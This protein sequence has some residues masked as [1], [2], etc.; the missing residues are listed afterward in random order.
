MRIR[1]IL[2]LLVQ[3]ALVAA[4]VVA[5]A[6][7]RLPLGIPG[8]WEWLRTP[9]PTTLIGPML[10]GMAVV[11]YAVI[12]AAGLRS[13]ADARR[14]AGL[15]REGCWL[16]TLVIAAIAIQAIIPTG[17]PG[18]F[19]LEK[20]G[21][22]NFTPSSSGYFRVAREQAARDPWAFLANYPTWIQGQDTLHIGT[23]PPGLIVAQ[24]LLMRAMER[25][26]GVAGAIERMMPV[27]A[28]TGLRLFE[29][30]T[31]YPIPQSD[32]AALYLTSLITL[33]AC[34]GTVAPLYVLARATAGP[35]V[36]WAAAAFWPVA[37]APVLFQ[38]I[39]DAAYPFLSSSALALAA[40]AARDDA[41][42]R[43][44]AWFLAFA[45]GAVLAFGCTFTLAFLP[46]GLIVGI[47]ILSAPGVPARRKV[48][49]VAVVGVAFLSL[50]ALGWA[51]TSASPI[52]IW[53][54]NLRKHAAFYDEYPRSYLPWLLVNP[55]ELSVALGLPAAAWCACGLLGVRRTPRAASITFGVLVL[56]DLIGRNMG[57]VAR[58]WML[59]LPPLLLAAGAGMERL[60]AGPAAM[61]VTAALLGFQT[62]A[63]QSM[64]QVVLPVEIGARSKEH[65]SHPHAQLGVDE[66]ELAAADEA[67]IGRQLD[68]L[69]AVA[70]ELDHVPRL[71]VREPAEREIDAA[72]LD[73]EG[74]GH[75]QRI[76]V[77]IRRG[78]AG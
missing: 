42:G 7:R 53:R 21:Y 10:A 29:D 4:L 17:A 76:D 3:A 5:V 46:V 13:L 35:R 64:I 60:G 25:S 56:L 45:S 47:L 12:V 39:A 15:V 58:L 43:R 73:G 77:G 66:D 20:W 48:G 54:W 63:I 78:A 49:L 16:A 40:W 67:A 6:G 1:A 19:G 2:I 14:P 38:P 9:A 8:E 28:T 52:T 65:V 33:L 61:A 70:A 51:V 26:P 24:C 30:A 72:Q 41:A 36:A 62:L 68:G 71:E 55:V 69:A 18:G 75:V 37:T 32:R 22:A 57:E 74:D 31:S 59:F 27:A 50:T 11:G 34:A 23:H 44:V